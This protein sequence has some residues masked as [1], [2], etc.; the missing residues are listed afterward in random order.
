MG[1]QWKQCQTLFLGGSK[2]TADGDCSQEIKRCLLLGRKIMTT[3]SLS[4]LLELVM[5]REAWR[6]AI[7]GVTK[8]RTQ[9]SDWTELMS[10]LFPE[11]AW[12]TPGEGQPQFIYRLVKVKS[13]L[14]LCDPMDCSLPG[15]FIHGIFPGKSTGVGCHFLLQGIFS[16]PEISVY[17]CIPLRIYIYLLSR[18]TIVKLAWL[19]FIILG[20]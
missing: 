20:R 11:E 5:D 19:C 1:K 8:S 14:T 6:A 2:I 13:W 7:H 15:S 12:K 4:E 16:E 9:L 17:C 10:L 18:I 3:W